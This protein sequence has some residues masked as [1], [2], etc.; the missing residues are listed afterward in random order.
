[1]TSG[2]NVGAGESYQDGA[3][4]IEP[5]L[6][7]NSNK[8]SL[9]SLAGPGLGLSSLAGSGPG[10]STNP[11]NGYARFGPSSSITPTP[12]HQIQIKTMPGLQIQGFQIQDPLF[13]ELQLQLSQRI[14]LVI[15]SLA[16]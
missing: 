14:L 1:M 6:F 2:M 15:I 3:V 4:R 13:L 12:V 11:N 10:F 16:G 5:P 9:S 7:P 8:A